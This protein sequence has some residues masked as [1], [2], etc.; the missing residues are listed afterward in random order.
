MGRGVLVLTA[1]LVLAL[2]GAS[3]AVQPGKTLTFDKS[4][5]GPVAF[6]GRKHAEAGLKCTDCHKADLF[7]RMKKGTVKITMDDIYEGK[8]CGACHDGSKAF[9]PRENCTRCHVKK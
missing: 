3:L 5:L 8:F 2:V 6:D 9:A 7:P 4:N 1:I